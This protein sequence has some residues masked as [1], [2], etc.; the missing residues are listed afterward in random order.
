[1]E[2][3]QTVIRAEHLVRTYKVLNGGK[4]FWSRLFSHDYREVRAVDD[5]SFGIQK[6]EIVGFI[7]PNGAGKSTAIKMMTGILVPTDGHVTVL[8]KE[9]CRHR[10]ENAFHIGVVFGQ[11]SQL[12]WDLPLSDT[13]RLLKKMYR[14][15]DSTYEKN[16]N[17]FMDKLDMKRFFEQPVR[18]LSLG[19]RMRGEIAAAML[20]DPEILFLDEPTI[21]LDVVAKQQMREF[22]RTINRERGVTIILTTHDMK[23]ME[24]LC[25]RIVLIN[26]GKVVLDMPLSEM[27]ARFGKTRDVA[28][29]FEETPD[30]SEMQ[31]GCEVIRKGSLEY[32]FRVGA[33]GGN[34]SRLVAEAVSS[35]KIQDISIKETDIEEM[36]R[37]IYEET[38]E[39]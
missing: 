10:K 31:K 15:P 19:Q 30:L 29:T 6:G 39:A 8:G 24:D 38:G 4:G 9:P 12:W 27:K 3:S 28:V 11:R 2:S 18:Q 1:M 26:K 20:H 36:I 35:F 34:V 7:G 25:R 33:D 37:R 13:F 21:G 22:I 16:L 23:D 32:V 17:I 5:I 14:I